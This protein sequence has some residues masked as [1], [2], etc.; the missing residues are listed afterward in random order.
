MTLYTIQ[1]QIDQKND[2]IRSENMTR[3]EFVESNH[4]NRGFHAPSRNGHR[5]R[6]TM[7]DS[8]SSQNGQN[9]QNGQDSQ[10]SLRVFEDLDMI[11]M[12]PRVHRRSDVQDL[13]PNRLVDNQRDRSQGQGWEPI[14]HNGP[15]GPRLLESS[16][17]CQRHLGKEND[18][19]YQVSYDEKSRSLSERKDIPRPVPRTISETISQRPRRGPRKDSRRRCIFHR[20]TVRT[21]TTTKRP[22]RC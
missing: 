8:Q 7:P 6:R 15:V 10:R 18:P 14:D 2:E 9:G 17:V 16:R 22:I 3:Q 12:P 21:T 20:T 4:Y 13:D 1:E 11:R 5:S 19:R